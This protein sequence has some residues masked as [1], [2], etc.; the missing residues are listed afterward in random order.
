[1]YVGLPLNK[2]SRRTY[3]AVNRQ[4]NHRLTAGV[5]QVENGKAPVTENRA[6]ESLNF[7]GIRPTM[8]ERAQHVP[9]CRSGALLVRRSN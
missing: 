9:D 5:A 1:V 3:A 8:R 7:L 4:H 2:P 6:I